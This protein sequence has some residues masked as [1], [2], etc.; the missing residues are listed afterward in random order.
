MCLLTRLIAASDDGATAETWTRH[1]DLF[2][3][4]DGI[5]A[6]VG[7]EWL[8]QT[9][10]AWAGF[11]AFGSTEA[12]APGLLLGA[13]RYRARVPVFAFDQ[14]IQ[15]TITVDFVA[16]NGVTQVSGELRRTETGEL[17]L[18]HGSLTLYRPDSMPTLGDA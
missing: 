3:E 15:V 16:D 14:R 11:R 17:P 5:P 13:K 8:A 2:A 10:A 12:A 9:V 7:V 6:W 1:D 4:T 18:A